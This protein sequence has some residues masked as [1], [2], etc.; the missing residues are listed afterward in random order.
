MTHAGEVAEDPFAEK[1]MQV[2]LP[3]LGTNHL[4]NYEL[5]RTH[6]RLLTTE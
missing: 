5:R 1:A 2:R 6:L 3:P 4:N